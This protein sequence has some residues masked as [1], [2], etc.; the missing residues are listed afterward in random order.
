VYSKCCKPVTASSQVL[1]NACCDGMPWSRAVSAREAE[2]GFK[3]LLTEANPVIN[4]GSSWPSVKRSVRTCM[5]VQCESQACSLPGLRCRSMS[6]I[7]ARDCFSTVS[8]PASSCSVMLRRTEAVSVG[9]VEKVTLLLQ[10]TSCH[11]LQIW[12][13]QRYEELSERERR[14]LFTEYRDVLREAEHEDALVSG[15]VDNSC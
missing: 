2:L 6:D 1:I 3:Q 7:A 12:S 8:P 14:R 4:G 15:A 9:A 5:L 10:E 11:L 13:D